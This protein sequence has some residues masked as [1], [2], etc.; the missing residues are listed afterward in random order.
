MTIITISQLLPPAFYWSSAKRSLHRDRMGRTRLHP[1]SVEPSILTFASQ[2]S[3]TKA[4][5]DF[6]CMYRL[7]TTMYSMYSR[8]ADGQVC[9][10]LFLCHMEMG[11][12]L[13]SRVEALEQMALNMRRDT[14]KILDMCHGDVN[15]NGLIVF[16]CLEVAPPTKM[17]FAVCGFILWWEWAQKITCFTCAEKNQEDVLYIILRTF[18]GAKVS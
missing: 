11:S 6:E 2:G 15:P 1:W 3:D 12:D 13:R 5:N 10:Q 14:E 4:R 17:S 7:L 18:T 16:R 8:Q 9:L